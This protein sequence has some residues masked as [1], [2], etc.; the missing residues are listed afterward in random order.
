MA[1]L[2]LDLYMLLNGINDHLMECHTIYYNVK[3]LSLQSEIIHFS[4]FIALIEKH[5]TS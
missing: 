2:E 3:K 1:C 5:S 4:L